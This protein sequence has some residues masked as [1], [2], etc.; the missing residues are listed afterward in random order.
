M[1]IRLFG[2]SLFSPVRGMSGQGTARRQ[3]GYD[4]YD[5]NMVEVKSKVSNGLVSTT[6]PSNSNSV[7][8]SMLLAM[9]VM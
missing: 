9:V 8:L 6:T 1:S 3:P 5:P 7:Y 4:P 2:F